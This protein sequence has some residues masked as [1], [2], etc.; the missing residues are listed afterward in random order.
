MELTVNITMG[1]YL[2]VTGVSDIRKKTVNILL[3]STGIIPVILSFFIN[4]GPDLTDRCIGL[5]PGIIILAIAVLS[6]EKIGKA[7]AF[8]FCIIGATFGLAGE[9]AF[10]GAAFLLASFASLAMLAM[11]RITRKSEIPFI[12][13]ILAGYL[14]VMILTR[15]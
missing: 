11:G 3:L 12:P 6:H 5:I 8:V 1:I 4:D 7:D 15:V 2:L 13:F 10:M 14:M 9:I